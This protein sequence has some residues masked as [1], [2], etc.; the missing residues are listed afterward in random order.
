[1]E[2][3]EKVRRDVINSRTSEEK[4][5]NFKSLSLGAVS[6]GGNM[7]VS[8]RTLPRLVAYMKLLK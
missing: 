5:K 8:V 1:M 3:R 4:K 7:H 6:R 2:V